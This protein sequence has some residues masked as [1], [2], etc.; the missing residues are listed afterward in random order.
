MYENE[1]EKVCNFVNLTAMAGVHPTGSRRTQ[2]KW[3][4]RGLQSAFCSDPSHVQATELIK[5]VKRKGWQQCRSLSGVIIHACLKERV[6]TFDS[7]LT[8]VKIH[9]SN[10]IRETPFST[11]YS[12][13]YSITFREKKKKIIINIFRRDQWDRSFIRPSALDG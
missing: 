6:E 3:Q 4:R 5:C 1:R 12:T 9:P 8:L 13:R 11:H 2:K 10:S 7:P